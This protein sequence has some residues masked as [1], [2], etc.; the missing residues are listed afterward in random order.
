MNCSFCHKVVEVVPVHYSAD[1]R[2]EVVMFAHETID[3]EKIKKQ[4]LDSK[5]EGKYKIMSHIYILDHDMDNEDKC[6]QFS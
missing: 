5:L 3:V 2:F 1:N 6:V 4:I